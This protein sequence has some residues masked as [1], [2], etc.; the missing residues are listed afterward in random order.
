[1]LRGRRFVDFKFRRQHP[2]GP[3]F[4][5][6]FCIQAQLAVELD[7][8]GHGFPGQRAR[9]ESRNRFLASKGIRV[10]RFWNHQVRDALESVRFEI[11]CA[12][13]ERTSRTEELARYKPK[14]NAPI[15]AARCIGG[16]DCERVADV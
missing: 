8:S 16:E 11:W 3:Y 2:C 4:L 7:G 10:L 9:D 15:E 14:P 13:M 1:L 12:L 6:F 5:D